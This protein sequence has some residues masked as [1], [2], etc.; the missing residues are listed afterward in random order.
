[1]TVRLFYFSMSSRVLPELPLCIG[2]SGRKYK[3]ERREM[4][5]EYIEGKKD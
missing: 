3:D 2:N 5:V 1:M 4:Y